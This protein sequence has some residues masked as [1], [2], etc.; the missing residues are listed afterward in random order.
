VNASPAP[1]RIGIIGSG[2]MGAQHAQFV[3]DE[4][5]TVLT[6]IADP[7]N[8]EVAARFG[9]AHFMDYRDMLASGEIDAVLIVNPNALHVET[10]LACLEAGIPALLEK[11]VAV[12]IEDAQPLLAA[13]AQSSTPILVGQHRR[14][15]PAVAAARK[16]IAEGTLGDL[17]AING[18]W[19]T[20]KSDAYY[21]EVE[22]HRKKGAGVILINLVHDLDLLRFIVGEIVSVQAAVSSATRGLEVE[23][24][25]S[26]VVR[27]ADGA[28]GSF[29]ASD[30]AVSPYTW[31]QAVKDDTSFPYNEDSF[32]YVLAGTKGSLTFPKLTLHGYAPNEAHPDWNHDLTV[33]QLPQTDGHSYANQLRHFVKVVRGE[34]EPIVTVADAVRTMQ[35]LEAVTTSSVTGATVTI[36]Q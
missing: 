18:M 15:H 7:F 17:V 34:A 19:I 25:A 11:P 26:L 24:T 22:W 12:S 29:M 35:L 33:S 2:F 3:T 36:E 9:V 23:D 32:A 5:Q 31:D 28:L 20:R 8:T 1:L 4:P 30:A 13:V 27:F 16:A 6:A 14:H 10:A 21:S